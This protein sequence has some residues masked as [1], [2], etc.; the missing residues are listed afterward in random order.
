MEDIRLMHSFISNF[1]KIVYVIFSL[2]IIFLCCIFFLIAC[3]KVTCPAAS[4]MFDFYKMDNYSFDVIN[5]GS[6]HVYCSI[7]TIE[8]YRRRGITSYN[9]AAGS[10]PVWF[11][12]Y[13]IVR[14]LFSADK[15]SG[16]SR[17]SLYYNS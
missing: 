16:F 13:Y 6:S 15:S 10:Q 1:K 17:N 9:L 14:S 11:S 5:V 2:A 12:Y 8:M 4:N 7:N 3:F